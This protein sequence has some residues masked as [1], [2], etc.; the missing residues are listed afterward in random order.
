MGFQFNTDCEGPISKNDNA[1][2]LSEFYIPNGHRF[3]AMVSK[4]DDFLAD[5][6]RRPGYKAGD[7]LKL[8]L[9]FLKAFGITDRGMRQFSR[10]HLLL[11]PEAKEAL[12]EINALMET[13][14]ISTSYEPY[15]DAL[16]EVLEFPKDRTYS[17]Q[18][19]LDKYLLKN[20]EKERLINLAKEI[21]GMEMMEWPE[22]AQ[23]LDDL[24][25][26]DRKTIQR[27]DQIFWREIEKM[28]IGKILSEVNPVG[29]K[30]KANAVLQ[31]M[32]RTGN[33]L[34]EVIYAGDSITDV[35]A[36]DLVR[37]GGG[38]TISFNGNRYALRSAEVAC[39]S[40]HAFILAIFAD[41]FKKG[42]RKGLMQIVDRWGADSLTSMGIDPQ[43]VQRLTSSSSE[44][45]PKV[46]RITD[47]NRAMLIQESEVF[48][49]KVRGIK[50]GSL[51]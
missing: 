15:I 9:P 1:M 35:E 51:G 43:W 8:I 10:E 22:K 42:G 6:E 39:L 3:F 14:I 38:I 31:S 48:R 40:P 28:A 18:V 45:F 44:D 26:H 11:V 23:G 46:Y 5:I 7:T 50:I 29:G 21:Q 41:A 30:E 17:T 32:E 37:K 19:S 25:G 27:L 2:E 20:E 33:S 4:Y 47:E 13:F 16:C 49:K 12:Q 36:F 24:S 34:E